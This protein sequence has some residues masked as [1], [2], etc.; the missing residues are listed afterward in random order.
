MSF[1]AGFVNVEVVTSKP[2]VALR[3]VR[4]AYS[5]LYSWLAYLLVV[6]IALH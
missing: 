1:R 3:R 6:A 5:C 2:F 4:S